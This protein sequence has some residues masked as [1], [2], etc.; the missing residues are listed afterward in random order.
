ME[1]QSLQTN[2]ADFLIWC[3][4]DVTMSRQDHINIEAKPFSTGKPKVKLSTEK[5]KSKNNT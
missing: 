1:L 5:K 2:A 4:S 3:R